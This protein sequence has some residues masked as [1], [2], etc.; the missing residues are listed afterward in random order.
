MD[1]TVFAPGNALPEK[2]LIEDPACTQNIH[3]PP[4]VKVASLPG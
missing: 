2:V 3:G 4:S 1:R